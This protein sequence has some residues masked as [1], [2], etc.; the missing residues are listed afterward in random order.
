MGLATVQALW[1]ALRR[2]ASNQ[3][4]L[5]G[6]RK[7]QASTTT[8]IKVTT[9]SLAVR[10]AG[11]QQRLKMPRQDAY[12]SP[13][14]GACVSADATEDLAEEE[15]HRAT[16]A[17]GQRRIQERW[18]SLASGTRDVLQESGC[19]TDRGKRVPVGDELG[20]APQ[21]DIASLEYALGVMSRCTA[22]S[23]RD[24]HRAGEDVP[25]DAL[26]DEV[27]AQ[28]NEVLSVP[29]WRD[30]VFLR[31]GLAAT[32]QHELACAMVAAG[33]E[34]EVSTSVVFLTVIAMAVLLLISPIPLGFALVSATHGELGGTIVAL[35]GLAVCIY[36]VWWAK[37]K[38]A[39]TDIPEAERRYIAWSQFRHVHGTGS[40]GA[41][42][43][44]YLVQMAARG[45]P[46]PAVAFDLCA[47]LQARS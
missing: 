39:G 30:P 21:H 10:V 18:K 20:V 42:A 44:H 33:P 26:S 40:I 1:R 7:V 32:A 36:P 25:G 17:L 34:K 12:S 38:Q 4:V 3:L 15:E 16:C 29:A 35:Y 37:Q 45:V 23:R 13:T 14:E 6:Q 46:V 5:A 28:C 31:L 24:R 43:Q 9:A 47:A 11:L 2:A 27:L 22:A 41:G 8:Q 19:Y